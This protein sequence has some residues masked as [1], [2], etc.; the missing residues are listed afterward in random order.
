MPSNGMVTCSLGDDGIPSYGETCTT[1]CNTGYDVDGEGT[2][3]CQN[4]GSWSGSSA[5]CKIGKFV[6]ISN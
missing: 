2:R 1:I 3:T 4:N 6:H 5:T